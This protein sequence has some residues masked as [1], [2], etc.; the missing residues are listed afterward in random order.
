[1][2]LVA[3]TVEEAAIELALDLDN[4]ILPIQGPPGAGKT[5]IGSRMIAALA[6][7]GKRVGVTAVSHKVILNLLTS[8]VE[9]SDDGVV[10]RVAHQSGSF[11]ADNFRDQ[12]S[13]LGL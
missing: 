12:V 7:S 8:V 4:S 1:M 9:N 5:Y 11:E 6:R 13:R 2:P 10:V 3:P